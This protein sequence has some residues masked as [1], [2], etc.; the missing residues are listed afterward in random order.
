MLI[1]DH[2][3]VSKDGKEIMHAL[4]DAQACSKRG[5]YPG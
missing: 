3:S 2:M 4:N 5:Q 1:T